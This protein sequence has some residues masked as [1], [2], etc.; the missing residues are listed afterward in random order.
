[1]TYFCLESTHWILAKILKSLQTKLWF[2]DTMKAL[3][4]IHVVWGD[5]SPEQFLHEKY[6]YIYTQFSPSS[7]SVS[8]PAGFK[9]GVGCV[10]QGCVFWLQSSVQNI[11]N[12]SLPLPSA[13]FG[14]GCCHF[15]YPCIS[16]RGIL[17]FLKN[18]SK[19]SLSAR[20]GRCRCSFPQPPPGIPVAGHGCFSS[21]ASRQWL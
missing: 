1:M 9:M 8:Q 18:G 3:G 6:I 10:W 15:V 19:A 11:R 2:R 12:Q 17:I 7:P 14:L 21:P 16:V 4:F 13:I 5:F 20:R